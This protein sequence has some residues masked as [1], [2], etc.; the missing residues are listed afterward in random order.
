MNLVRKFKICKLLN[1]ENE[2]SNFFDYIKDFFS[3]LDIQHYNNNSINFSCGE[4]LIFT[5]NNIYKD[6]YIFSISEFYDYFLKYKFFYKNTN[7]TKK[8]EFITF[9]FKIYFDLE[10]NDISYGW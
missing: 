6:V 1:I 9:Y 2:Y 10:I 3:M 5:Y 7:G 8:L 4:K